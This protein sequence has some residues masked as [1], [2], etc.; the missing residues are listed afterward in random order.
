MSNFKDSLQKCKKWVY[1]FIFGICSF[2]CLIF[3]V[4]VAY[5]IAIDVE[6][7]TGMIIFGFAGVLLVAIPFYCY[8]Y[9]KIVRAEKHK[10]IFAIYNSVVITLIY[11]LP[12]VFE[13]DPW[14]VGA[15]V[16]VWL[17]SWSI[18][19]LFIRQKVNDSVN[20]TVSDDVTES[21]EEIIE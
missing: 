5:C 16:F 20:D 9:T 19:P 18:V 2:V 3:V 14:A 7:F 21:N 11:I 13:K 6:D 4:P 8:R 15:I 1:P 10:F 17:C 12:F